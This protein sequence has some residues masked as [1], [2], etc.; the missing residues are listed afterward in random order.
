ME[1]STIGMSC[2]ALGWF[3]LCLVKKQLYQP[4]RRQN[5]P[6]LYQLKTQLQIRKRKRKFIYLALRSAEWGSSGFLQI[7]LTYSSNH[8]GISGH[9]IA[10]SHT[11][12]MFLFPLLNSASN[13]WLKCS[14]KSTSPIQISPHAQCILFPC[15]R[16]AQCTYLR[17]NTHMYMC[18][19]IVVGC[20]IFSTMPGVLSAYH[21]CMHSTHECGAWWNCDLLSKLGWPSAYY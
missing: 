1:R 17:T 16:S 11:T 8:W 21:A 15:L 14:Q 6:S 12:L 19:G 20:F 4:V 18:G 2:R 9:T 3:V 5:P 13:L 7:S 10:L